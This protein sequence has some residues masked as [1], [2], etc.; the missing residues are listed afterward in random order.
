MSI[1]GQKWPTSGDPQNWPSAS[2]PIKQ[3]CRNP[4]ELN[5]L[6]LINFSEIN[7]EHFWTLHDRALKIDQKLLRSTVKFPKKSVFSSQLPR[8]VPAGQ[9][10]AF[11]FYDHFIWRLTIFLDF[12]KIFSQIFFWLFICFADF[13]ADRCRHAS[14]W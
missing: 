5:F 1:F 2:V 8:V 13:L 3:L 10:P 11:F 7:F 9:R 4:W 14:Q 6:I 12:F